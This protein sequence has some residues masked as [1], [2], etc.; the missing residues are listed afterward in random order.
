M[1]V[2]L[3]LTTINCE[4]LMQFTT[5]GCDFFSIDFKVIVLISVVIYWYHLTLFVKSQPFE[6]YGWL[7][8]F[9][10]CHRKA[11]EM[12]PCHSRDLIR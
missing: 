9:P 10:A 4:V 12:D 5:S 2:I 6:V 8:Y 1:A 3:D 7:T 11:L